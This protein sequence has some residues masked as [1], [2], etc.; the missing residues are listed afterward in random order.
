[1][2]RNAATIQ[3]IADKWAGESCLLNGELAKVVGRVNGFATISPLDPEIGTA[4]YS[5]HTVDR[6]MNDDR[7]FC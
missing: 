5:W 2:E 6:I 4:S 3:R 7:K 1:M